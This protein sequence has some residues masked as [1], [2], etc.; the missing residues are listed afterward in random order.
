MFL[1]IS[2][3]WLFCKIV[4]ITR[5]HFCCAISLTHSLLSLSLSFAYVFTQFSCTIRSVQCNNG[6]EFDN[7]STYIFFL[8]HGVQLWM[9]CPYTSPQNGRVE[10]MIR[11]TNDVMLSLLFQASLPTRYWAKPS[12]CHLP[13][14]PPP[15]NAISSPSPTSL[16]P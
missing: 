6:C 7:F 10:R 1:D 16:S 11:T 14:Q 12:H 5:G 13:P 3:I 15:T 4:L 8:S 2:T 9:S